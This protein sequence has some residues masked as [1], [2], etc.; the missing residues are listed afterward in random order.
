MKKL[1]FIL[2]GLLIS[3][4]A[5]AAFVIG[6]DLYNYL[7]DLDTEAQE[8]TEESDPVE[9]R[10]I[11]G[12]KLTEEKL[13]EIERQGLNPFGEK[14]DLGELNDKDYQEYIHGMSHQKVKADEK[15]GFFEITEDRIN[16][17]L[18]GL[19]EVELSNEEVYR[20]ILT[21]W[22]IGDFSRVDVNHNTVWE[23]QN[24]TIGKATGI[25]SEA[26]EEAYINSQR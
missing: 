16:W 6:P 17:L 3:A 24:G 13:A 2:I 22:S 12:G 25:L 9:S 4:L 11:A 1:I 23:M 26:E 5:A 21:R 15:W 19:S 8:E 10:E 14:K 7:T 18:E 20:D